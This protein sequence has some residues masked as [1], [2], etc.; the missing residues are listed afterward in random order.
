MK[1]R[2]CKAVT[3]LFDTGLN[4]RGM[5]QPAVARYLFTADGGFDRFHASSN[6]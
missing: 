4:C 3:A 2:Q 1:R 6:I 5:S